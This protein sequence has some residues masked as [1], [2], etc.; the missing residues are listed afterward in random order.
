MAFLVVADTVMAHG[1]MAYIVMAYT[2]MAR[3]AGAARPGAHR[4]RVEEGGRARHL[5]AAFFRGTHR[6]NTLSKTICITT[7]AIADL[8]LRRAQVC[9]YSSA[10][11]HTHVYAHVCTHG[12]WAADHSVGLQSGPR[13]LHFL[14]FCLEPH[15]QSSLGLGLTGFFA[16]C[17]FFVAMPFVIVTLSIFFVFDCIF[18]QQP[19]NQAGHTH[20]QIATPH[21]HLLTT[22][23][24]Y[25]PYRPDTRRTP[26]LML[27]TTLQ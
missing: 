6:S 27:A 19:S 26:P 1:V 14:Y 4:E 5:R 16:V 23:L 15:G 11:F 13:M 8:L 22:P 9:A 12:Q 18:S 3:R 24:S 20:H 10:H 21:R 2:V 7:S 25:P 17:V